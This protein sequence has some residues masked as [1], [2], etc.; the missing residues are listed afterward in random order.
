MRWRRV[1]GRDRKGSGRRSGVVSRRN[2]GAA[3]LRGGLGLAGVQDGGA[4]AAVGTVEH[5]DVAADAA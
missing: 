5:L 3:G 4:D 2:P 1:G